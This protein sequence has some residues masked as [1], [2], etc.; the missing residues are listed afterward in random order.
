MKVFYHFVVILIVLLITSMESTAQE[1]FQKFEN[2]SHSIGSD[3]LTL[4]NYN[5]VFT[6][7]DVEK[8]ESTQKGKFKKTGSLFFAFE[9]AQ[10]EEIAVVE[11]KDSKNSITITSKHVLF[12]DGNKNKVEPFF[13]S[14]LSYQFSR[15]SYG[16]KNNK[17]NVNKEFIGQEGKL[18]EFIHLPDLVTP[19]DQL[20]IETYLSLKY[21]ISL[22]QTAYVATSSDT[23]WDFEKNKDF[24][25]RVTGI[26]R[27]DKIG[28]YQPKS[29]NS[30]MKAISIGVDSLNTIQNY[31]FMIWSDNDAETTIQ[32]STL[33]E[34]K[35]QVNYFGEKK[36]FENLQMEVDPK[37]LFEKYDNR[38]ESTDHVLWLVLS[39]TPNF[40]SEKKY[41]KYTKTKNDKFVFEKINFSEH[42]YFTFLI[43]PEFFVETELILSI[44]EQTNQL[45]VIPIGGVLPYQLK[46]N[47]EKF[48]DEFQF[49]EPDYIQSNLPSGNYFLEITDGFQNQY[50]TTFTIIDSK[51]FTI[52]LKEKWILLDENEII[53]FPQVSNP[54]QILNYE[55]IRNNEVVASTSTLKTGQTGAYQLQV[56]LENGCVETRDFEVVSQDVLTNQINIYPNSTA[57]GQLFYVDFDLAEPKDITVFI[58]DMAG[59]IIL[60]ER[61]LAIE[62]Y[63]F[64]TSLTVSG[65][66]LLTVST[67]KATVAKRII[68]K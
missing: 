44:C 36:D 17:L 43:A 13:G 15:D 68:V 16:R 55:W 19:L 26:G 59:K 18:L 51:P 35:W 41:V 20:K 31:S 47:S 7:S 38:L 57:S 12:S 53:I 65:T 37:F 58:H 2:I 66:Y 33:L 10:E 54:N 42:P 48:N 32:K 5:P 61:L 11:M 8:L 60:N 22:Y 21:G 29:V 23:I 27:D 34:R 56:N 1:F 62:D 6:S 40:K 45:K 39:K 63:Q 50:S 9:S 14:I 67:D 4:Q 64:K 46:L 24:A 52:D 28:L 25:N 30:E 3:S 49:N